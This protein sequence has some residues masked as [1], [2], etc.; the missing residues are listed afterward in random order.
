M[1]EGKLNVI[2]GGLSHLVD[3]LRCKDAQL[4]L[5][6]LPGVTPQNNDRGLLSSPCLGR[7]GVIASR[8]PASNDGTAAHTFDSGQ[9]E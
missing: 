4:T 3:Q 2:L 5:Q 8:H 1:L 6:N 7:E 9:P